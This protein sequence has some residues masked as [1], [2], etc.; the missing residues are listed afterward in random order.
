VGGFCYAGGV[1]SFF[2][3]DL[4]TS[5]LSARTSRI[6]QF[7]G[8]RTDMDLNPV[9]E[10]FNILV[11]LNDD[12]LPDPGAVMVTGITPQQTLADGISEAEFA[13]L[14]MDQVFTPDT[15]TLGFNS[16]RFDDEFIRHLFWRN[17]Y[18]PY[19]WAWSEGRSRWDML[20]VIRMTR[21]LRP[22]GIKWPVDENGKA[23]NRLELISKLNGLNHTKAHDALSDVEALIDVAKLI[24]SKQPKLFDY[25]LGMRDKKRVADLVNLESPQPFVYSSGRYDGN[26]EKTTV[27]FPIA[28]GPNPGS[29]L[30]YDLRHDPSK[31]AGA[32]PKALSEVLFASYEQRQD[33]DFQALPIKVLTYNKCPAVAPVGVIDSDEAWKRLGLT[34]DGIQANLKKLIAQTD[35]GARAREAFEM[36]EP[37]EPTT[38]VDQQLYDGFINDKD[39]GRM[40][41]VRAADANA[42]ADFHPE[43][44]DDRLDELLLRYKARQFP[45]S[46]SEDERTTW[47]AW[48]AKKLQA[49]LPRYLQTLQKLATSG[50]D[51]FVL[52]ELQLWA[53]SIMPEPSS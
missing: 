42:L 15:V 8:Q 51:Q 14:L 26:Y 16:I 5:G 18:D 39:K 10:P 45:A 48:R 41:A 33:P 9:G 38:D 47:E 12:T 43:F 25:L 6:M 49:E 23:T 44:S 22:D 24:K 28:P 4:E 17:F 1:K 19:E 53:E 3:Y 35:L 37:F 50:A 30:V 36:R 29:V 11:R 52:E 34:L 21:A 40:S 13:K 7:A 46:L 32:I 20:D 31:F 27:A 2:F